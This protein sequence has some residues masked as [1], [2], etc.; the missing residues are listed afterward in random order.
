MEKTLQGRGSATSFVHSATFGAC[1][2][3][4]AMSAPSLEEEVARMANDA[5]LDVWS[6]DS[7]SF[8]ARE[9]ESVGGITVTGIIGSSAYYV[10]CWPGLG[11]VQSMV[12]S[13]VEEGTTKDE[14]KAKAVCFFG[15]LKDFFRAVRFRIYKSTEH[16]VDV[17]EALAERQR[18]AS[19]RTARA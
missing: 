12:H 18:V 16:P 9:G 7:R 8:G 4:E 5:G 17:P 13:C 15:L 6:T 19:L 3:V 10:H 2:N 1:L 14:D 11:S